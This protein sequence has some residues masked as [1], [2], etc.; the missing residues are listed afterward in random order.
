MKAVTPF[1]RRVAIENY[2]AE[3]QPVVN[4]LL[5]LHKVMPLTY[6]QTKTGLEKNWQK[7]L[8]KLGQIGPRSRL[9]WRKIFWKKLKRD[10]L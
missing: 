6:I 8:A 9:K 7:I 2:T 5:E 4:M 10:T 3:C 1:E